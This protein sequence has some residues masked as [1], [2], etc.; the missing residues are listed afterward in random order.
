MATFIPPWLNIDPIEPAKIKLQ[1]NAQR[2]QR[3]AAELT[4]Q[5]ARERMQEEALQHAGTLAARQQEAA[6]LAAYR[7]QESE[8]K[9]QEGAALERLRQQK[10]EQDAMEASIRMEGMRD[11]E[12]GLAAGE[13]QGTA[14][15]RNAHK[16]LYKN[17]AALERYVQNLGEAGPLEERT[18]SGGAGY[19]V[20]PGGRP[21]FIPRTSLP[22]ESF[23][24]GEGGLMEIAPGLNMVRTSKNAAQVINKPMA[25]GQFDDIQTAMMKR[26]EE[27]EKFYRNQLKNYDAEELKTNPQAKELKQFIDELGGKREEIYEAARREKRQ[28]QLTT[29]TT[30]AEYDDLAPGTYYKKKDGR[31]G[32]KP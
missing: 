13:D 25:P 1:A 29:V 20:R 2:N 30:Q 3:A 18:T 19:L 11:Y 22:G 14:F 27:D 9:E 15:S 28:Q 7:Q 17:P 6:D 26:I 21:Q 32:Y 16:L 10:Y 5:I 23:T 8:R 24:P 12:K 4:A 31:T